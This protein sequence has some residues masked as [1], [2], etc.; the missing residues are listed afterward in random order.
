M[1]W[2]FI[3][4][5]RGAKERYAP[6]LMTDPVVRF[7]D[8]TF[9]LWA[10]GGLA[11]C[12]S[13]SATRSAA[14]STP[15]LTGLLWGGAVRMLV[16]HH[17]T[18]SI[19]S[20]CHFF[21]RR[22]FDTGDHSRNLLWLALPTFGESWHNNHHAFPTSAAHGLRRWEIDPSGARDPRCSSGSAWCGT[23]CAIDPE[24][25][26]RRRSP[27][28]PSRRLVRRPPPA[29]CAREL[30]RAL[31]DRPFALELWDGTRVAATT[32]NGPD[33]HASARPRPWPTCCARRG[34]SASAAPTSPATL[35]LDDLDAAHRAARP[36]AAAA[37]RPARAR[38]GS[39]LA[40]ARACGAAPARRAPAAELR[41]RGRR[42]S[43]E[44]DARAVRHHYDLPP[45]FFALFLGESMTYSCALFSRGAS[46]LEEAQERQARA[47]L[48]ASSR[49]SPASACSTSAAAGEAS[50]S[51]RPSATACR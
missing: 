24:R 39:P 27:R 48:P 31:P 28:P 14:R 40:A 43:I 8:R 3:H 6:D 5:Q 45:E 12:R 19:N 51:T 35:E 18:Y 20:L 13:A 21:G 36:L 33:L 10:L 32:G 46:T 25:Q 26:A 30:E 7:V 11:I 23:W 17:V 37:A 29:L 42:H 44:R 9:L 4:T 49:C 15:A 16:V 38:R 34:S 1:G 2:L 47:G 41:P 50:P 22:S